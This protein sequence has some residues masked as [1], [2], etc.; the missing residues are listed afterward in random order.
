MPPHLNS[1]TDLN[2]TQA[3]NLARA[4]LLAGTIIHQSIFS[5]V[6]VYFLSG[7]F[8]NVGNWWQVW[9]PDNDNHHRPTRYLQDT[10]SPDGQRSV[11]VRDMSLLENWGNEFGKPELGRLITQNDDYND[12]S[13]V[14][15][16]GDEAERGGLWGPKT[17]HIGNW[18]DEKEERER[19]ALRTRLKNERNGS[20]DAVPQ[21]VLDYGKFCFYQHRISNLRPAFLPQRQQKNSIV[22]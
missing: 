22:S 3:D 4:T 7:L 8:T 21:F 15:R 9:T 6:F 1:T 17:S 13:K 5:T 14:I 11:P 16:P 20:F 2:T 19:A 12:H 18:A 10:I